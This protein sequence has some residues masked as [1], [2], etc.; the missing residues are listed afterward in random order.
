MGIDTE[1]TANIV[2]TYQNMFDNWMQPKARALQLFREGGF[3]TI[4]EYCYHLRD[5]RAED[6]VQLKA[7]LRFIFGLHN[8]EKDFTQSDYY[9]FIQRLFKPDDLS[10]LR[11]DVVVLSYNYD[12]YLEWLLRRAYHRRKAALTRNPTPDPKIDGAITSGFSSGRPGLDEVINGG[13]F[14]MLKLHGIAAWPNP[15]LNAM[16]A[17]LSAHCSF[18]DYFNTDLFRRIQSLTG[19]VGNTETPI[20]FPWE[21]YEKNGDLVGRER[22]ALKDQPLEFSNQQFRHGCRMIT[23]PSLHDIFLAVWNRAKIEVQAASK[24]SFVGI[25]MHDYLRGGFRFLFHGINSKVNLTITDKQSI[26]NSTGA[27]ESYTPTGKFV[28]MRNRD[29]SGLTF[30]PIGIRVNFADFISKDLN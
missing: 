30:G 2:P 15:P 22:F 4:D 14:C 8:P 1:S 5:A 25:S 3:G 16:H 19:E 26:G 9:G 18:D 20:V 11:D 24:I 6:V 29:F 28:A 23:D 12:G 17:S 13:R 21:V 7:L 10:S 27:Y